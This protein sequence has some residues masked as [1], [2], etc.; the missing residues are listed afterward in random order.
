MKA[1]FKKKFIDYEKESHTTA[2]NWA[3]NI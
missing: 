3:N 1:Q 2:V